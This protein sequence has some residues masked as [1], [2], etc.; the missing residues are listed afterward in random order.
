MTMLERPPTTGGASP[1]TARQFWPRLCRTSPVPQFASVDRRKANTGWLFRR[2]VK[3]DAAKSQRRRRRLTPEPSRT[4]EVLGF[5]LSTILMSMPPWAL[6]VVGVDPEH[7]ASRRDR[8]RPTALGRQSDP[9]ERDLVMGIVRGA[10]ARAAVL[11][12][13]PARHG[14]AEVKGSSERRAFFRRWNDNSNLRR[15]RAFRPRTIV[16]PRCSAQ[17]GALW[18]RR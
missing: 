2:C 18:Q 5:L 14:L 3:G 13:R 4:P 9:R 17:S 12:S 10:I 7:T 8:Q 1:R 6:K 16:C 15:H 11:N